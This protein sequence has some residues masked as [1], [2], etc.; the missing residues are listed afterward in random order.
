MDGLFI[1]D[2]LPDFSAESA[3][4]IILNNASSL[5]ETLAED[6]YKQQFRKLDIVPR[7]SRHG[8]QK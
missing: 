7:I 5:D 4:D 8:E 3:K 6:R 2:E 1:K